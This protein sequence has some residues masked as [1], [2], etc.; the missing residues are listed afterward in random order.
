M[1]PPPDC[2]AA[3]DQQLVAWAREAREDAYAELLRRYQGPVFGLIY[4]IVRQREPAE[5]LTQETFIKAF[6][7]L[8]HHRAE[9]TFS[10]WIL[11]IANHAAVDHLR[12]S[13]LETLALETFLSDATPE[14]DK[15][16]AAPF[17]AP[18]RSDS[19]P[20]KVDAREL[21]RALE[22]A[23]RQR[24]RGNYRRCYV[25]HDLDERSYDDIAEL[26]G[27][28]PAAV[29]SYVSRARKQLR[30]V[31]GTPSNYLRHDSLTPA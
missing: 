23:V 16:T 27:L 12:R 5:D 4:R 1:T 26:L 29:R 11:S 2:G 19:T 22:R 31:L 30:D 10:A 8:D 20:V 24:L 15:P 7:A 9:R 21:R 14:Q 18:A 17:Q 13:Q 28:P 3:S 6:N 25:L